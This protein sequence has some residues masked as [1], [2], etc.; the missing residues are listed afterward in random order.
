M[1]KAVIEITPNRFVQKLQESIYHHI[2]RIEGRELLKLDFERKTKMVITD[3]VMQPGKKF[4]EIKWPKGVEI[5]N[6][7]R[8]EGDRVTV[9]MKGKAPGKTMEG[10]FKFFDLN[11]VY[12]MPFMATKDVIKFAAIGDTEALNKLIKVVGL[13]GKVRKVSFTQA[14][15]TNHDL[16][17]VL[18]DKQKEIL[19]EAKRRGYYDYPRKVNTQELSERLGISKAT[20]V[21]HLRKAEMRLMS[22]LLEGY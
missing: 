22:N 19:L 12:D 6:V 9:L 21:E 18:T 13:L 14:S 11:V 1:R 4:D 16:L 2:D 5:L 17:K 10:F 3:F 20:T 7:L 8:V 15:F